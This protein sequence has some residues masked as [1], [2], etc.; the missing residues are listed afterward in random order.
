MGVLKMSKTAKII[1]TASIIFLIYSVFEIIN[2]EN[3][4]K[5][6][7]NTINEHFK[8][9][10]TLEEELKDQYDEDFLVK[11]EDELFMV[12]VTDD[13]VKKVVKQ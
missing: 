8:K 9:P 6:Q 5:E 1:I 10:F 3:F 4:R 2:R 11:I 12:T 7:L 13:E